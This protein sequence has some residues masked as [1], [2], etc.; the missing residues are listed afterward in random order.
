M[1]RGSQKRDLSRL[2][3]LD[4]DDHIRRLE[5]GCRVGKDL[6]AGRLVRLVRTVDAIAC[7]GLDHHLMAM[8]HQLRHRSWG[9]PRTIPIDL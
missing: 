4:L 1:C 8:S 6:R 7:A 2:R 9:Q 3:L 5:D